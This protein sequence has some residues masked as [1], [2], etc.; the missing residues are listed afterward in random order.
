VVLVTTAGFEDN[1]Q[2]QRIDRRGLYDLAW[3]KA[4]PFAAWRDTIGVNERVLADG[5]VRTPL[6]A[7][8]IDRVAHLVKQLAC[9]DENVSIAICLL[10]SY[11]NSDHEQALARRLEEDVPGLS[12]S[13]SSDVA[14]IWREYERASTTVMDAYVG[15][16]V[17][18]FA[19][20]LGQSMSGGRVSGSHALMKSNG[21]Q[22][23]LQ[24]SGQRPA[25]LLL[26]GLAGGMI[27]GCHWARK[28]NVGRAITLDMGGTSADVGMVIDGQLKLS[29]LFEIEWG[30]PVALPI[31]DVTSVGAGGGSIARVDEGGMLRV[32]PQS[33]G[34][35]PG[36]ACYSLGGLE[37]TVTD[38]NLV[39]GRLN[40]EF[41]LGGQ[42]K[43]S[44]EL[45]QKALGQLAGELAMSAEQAAAAVIGVAVNNMANSIRLLAVDRGHDYRDFDLIAFGGAGPLHAAEIA[46]YLGV[47]RVLVPPAPGL[48]S[49]LG[50]L[51]A[52]ARV[53]R[54]RT[55]VRRLDLPSAGDLA[56]E[57]QHLAKLAAVALADQAG[58]EAVIQVDTSVACRYLGQ[59]YEQEV[60]TYQGHLDR[61]FELAVH[62]AP[63]VS[64]FPTKVADLFH[65]LHERSY[66]YALHDQPVQSVYLHVTA[67]VTSPTL[68][69]ASPSSA[70]Q[71]RH[72]QNRRTLATDGSEIESKIR[73]RDMLSPSDF[74]EGPALI[75]EADSTTYVP[76]GATSHLDRGGCLVISLFGVAP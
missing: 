20:S 66:G 31:I 8:E 65:D 6:V 30:V 19:G 28:L 68:E 44:P 7:E 71:L 22:V 60:R 53:D 26:S 40:P 70:S 18:K 9:Q 29:G 63:E 58:P 12:V 48:G 11:V 17:R 5:T 33:A 10:F 41:F 32:G 1:L 35:R 13:V 24:R 36:P 27:A 3:V 47:R 62:L 43:L 46:Q 69:L 23:P 25:E 4:Q 56:T 45:A 52:D 42:L 49:A 50:A 57:L 61:S 67:Q 38:A 74:L 2:I 59:N 55:C 34:A 72:P 54:R 14:P 64:D 51:I 76:P 75:E 37:A 21:G 73:R 15:P 16:L 39:A